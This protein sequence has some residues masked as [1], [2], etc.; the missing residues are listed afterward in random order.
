MRA[1]PE[2]QFEAAV[3]AFSLGDIELAGSFFADDCSIE[4]HPLCASFPS[5]DGA[6]GRDQILQCWSL[7]GQRFEALTFEARSI[8][9]VGPQIRAQIA[10]A[11]RHRTTFEVIDGSSRV[12][13]EFRAGKI[14]S[15][16]E[17]HDDARIRAFLRLCDAEV[18][19]QSG[20]AF[21]R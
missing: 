16:L 7:L 13:V 9:A 5:C 19:A 15:W 20:D 1:D 4:V 18:Y 8:K 10:Y 11:F 14:A 17:Y 3:G 2:G 21:T 12:E 6:A